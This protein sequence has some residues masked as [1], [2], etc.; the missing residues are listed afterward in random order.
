MD[1]VLND[2]V[3]VYVI[4]E[5]TG[6]IVRHAI[7]YT[8]EELLEKVKRYATKD[9]IVIASMDR[10]VYCFYIKREAYVVTITKTGASSKLINF[11]KDVLAGLYDNDRDA[12]YMEKGRVM[13]LFQ[14]ISDIDDSTVDVIINCLDDIW[15]TRYYSRFLRK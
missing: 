5:N 1:K 9:S 7:V 13:T 12:F 6:H 15:K 14:F 4:N 2:F 8:S 10:F 11:F 3:E